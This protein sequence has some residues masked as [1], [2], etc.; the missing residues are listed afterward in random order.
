MG[1]F[2]NENVDKIAKH[3]TTIAR[4]CKYGEKRTVYYN[5][6]K[7]PVQVDIAKDLIKLRRQRKKERK[8]FLLNEL[9]DYYKYRNEDKYRGDGIFMKAM[10]DVDHSVTNKSNQMNRELNYLN[11]NECEIIMK[12]R[13]EYINL[14]HYLHHINHHP[15]GLC[16]HCNVEE[17]VSHFLIDCIGFHDSL[18]LNLHQ[19]N[20]DFTIARKR[21]RQRLKK[22][23]IFFRNPINF[24]AKNILFP[25]LWQLKPIYDKRKK[26]DYHKKKAD[27]LIKRVEILKAVINFVR[28]TKRFKND[29]KY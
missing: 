12:L 23:A 14:N 20:I 5:M 7:N 17:T 1:I 24:S 25:H 6:G 13:T 22:I 16:D 26:S 8:M 19:D 28:E 3:A 11:Q 15:D 10:I 9:N 21:L 2:G 27:N 18:C 4:M 29:F